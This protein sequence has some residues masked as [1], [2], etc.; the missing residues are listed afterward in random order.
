MLY[1]SC[2]LFHFFLTLAYFFTLT[3]TEQKHFRSLEYR[4]C[5]SGALA[6]TVAHL[7]PMS[8]AMFALN[9][10]QK[11]CHQHSLRAGQGRTHSV[12]K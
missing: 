9:L 1:Y 10:H 12:C 7:I 11:L 8:I 3:F 5:N 6:L 4:V 2:L